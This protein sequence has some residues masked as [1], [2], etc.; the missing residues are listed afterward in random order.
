MLPI[1]YDDLGTINAVKILPYITNYNNYIQLYTEIDS[2]IEENDIIYISFSGDFSTYNKE[3]EIILD[4][5]MYTNESND[6]F[7]SDFSTGYVVLYVDKN[8]NSFVIN[9][10][11]N[12][13]PAQ[14]TLLAHYVSRVYCDNATIKNVKIDSSF[15]KNITIPINSDINWIQAVVYGGDINNITIKDKYN[16]NYI[17]LHLTDNKKLVS[18]NNNSFGYSYFYNLNTS[19]FDV[20]IKNSTFNNC[21]IKATTS[22]KKISNGEFTNC[23]IKNYDINNGYYI[24]TKLNADVNWN[25]GKWSSDDEFSLEY[26]KGGIFVNGVLSTNTTFQNGYFNGVF[27]GVFNGGTFQSGNYNGVLWNNGFLNNGLIN[28]PTKTLLINNLT[29]GDGVIDDAII[30]NSKLYGGEIKN[31]TIINSNVI[32]VNIINCLVVS[33]ILEKGDIKNSILENNT[34]NKNININTSSVFN[35]SVIGGKYTNNNFIS[36]IN[37]SKGE[38][39]NNTFNIELKTVN[40]SHIISKKLI[41]NNNIVDVMY[42]EIIGNNLFTI[43]DIGK[44]VYLNGFIN[45][46]PSATTISTKT[47]DDPSSYDNGYEQVLSVGE[48]YII[49]DL[50]DNTH[51]NK[52]GVVSLGVYDNT[53]L[54]QINNK[55]NIFGGNFQSDEFINIIV[56][57]GNFYDAYMHSGT[58]FNNGN[59]YSGNFSSDFTS[60]PQNIWNN[61]NFYNGVFGTIESGDFP[62]NYI[63]ILNNKTEI[64]NDTTYYKSIIIEEIYPISYIDD[65]TQNLNNNSGKY[66]N[67]PILNSWTPT[68]NNEYILDN[69][70]ISNSAKTLLNV[71][72]DEYNDKILPYKFALKVNTNNDENK[73]ALKTWLNK[74]SE[75]NGEITL[76]DPNISIT[77]PLTPTTQIYEE[78]NNLYE[79][80]YNFDYY[81][82]LANTHYMYFIFISDSIKKLWDEAN[83]TERIAYKKNYKNAWSIANSGYYTHPF[84]VISSTQSDVSLVTTYN[85]NY[86]DVASYNTTPTKWIYGSSV[87]PW[88]L[89]NDITLAND[90]F[91]HT[92]KSNKYEN[93]WQD[94]RLNQTHNNLTFSTPNMFNGASLEQYEIIANGQS[95]KNINITGDTQMFT[96]DIINLTNKL[97]ELSNTSLNTPFN[98]SLYDWFKY[99]NIHKNEYG[100]TNSGLTSK[101]KSNILTTTG[102]SSTS[103]PNW[104]L[105]GTI[106]SASSTSPAE[107]NITYISNNT[108]TLG[109]VYKIKVNFKGKIKI[110]KYSDAYNNDIYLDTFINNSGSY[111]TLSTSFISDGYEE[112]KIIIKS[113][114]YSNCYVD[115]VIM[116]SKKIESEVGDFWV[117]SNGVSY[118]GVPMIKQNEIYNS[119]NL[120][121]NTD[122]IYNF[123]T[124]DTVLFEAYY[125]S[126]KYDKP[127]GETLNSFTI[128]LNN[129][130]QLINHSY[131]KYYTEYTQQNIVNRS[132][133]IFYDMFLDTEKNHFKHINDT[134]QTSSLNFQREAGIQFKTTNTPTSKTSYHD[135]F[136]N[137]VFFNGSFKGVWGDGKWVSGN[138]HGWNDLISP[139]GEFSLTAPSETTPTIKLNIDDYEH[140]IQYLIKNGKY[141]DIPP[142]DN[143]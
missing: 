111:I 134:I 31:S 141:Y 100:K 37:I 69:P 67:D 120:V 35:N 55:I 74:I 4:N 33:S 64:N 82:D 91:N 52:Y 106:W 58:T 48:N 132:S 8:N 97:E 94:Y 107:L 49:L 110:Y 129:T 16:Y 84:P 15:I 46:T 113:I 71:W 89:N 30:E 125:K 136:N 103:T 101:Y 139:V 143:K 118:Y 54:N 6:F 2:H 66:G 88:W 98:S 130:G 115:S 3:T 102:W 73:L 41:Y 112:E 83:D 85:K 11:I 140:N 63:T 34:I 142:W 24:N 18:L 76:I 135:L 119:D 17:S 78:F 13:I 90:Q 20:D 25:Y 127:L 93:K 14:K 62:Y 109:R 56:N 65:Q 99:H 53:T 59:F 22:T 92:I 39:N 105:N 57:N 38:Y 121:M 23:N 10:E 12:T 68:P 42:V 123:N 81:L 40:F 7:Y 29:M 79:N 117:D 131:D 21:H 122:S 51:I 50:Y 72:D 104:T 124:Q 138:F 133:D 1:R 44:I 19:I 116:Q 108:L 137:G 95:L 32:G 45:N 61:G 60:E 87:P 128:S 5:I 77:N 75:A 43:S 36:P 26:W 47:Y 27:N 70:T 86:G 114:P 9:R 80:G 126:K 28:D 96:D